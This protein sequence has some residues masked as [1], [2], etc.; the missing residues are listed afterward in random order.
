[1]RSVHR[2]VSRPRSGSGLAGWTQSGAGHEPQWI[3]E[4]GLVEDGPENP[5][6]HSCDAAAIGSRASRT[7]T[8]ARNPMGSHAWQAA[9][10]PGAA[11]ASAYQVGR[12]RAPP[13][14]PRTPEVLR[15]RARAL[16][17]VRTPFSHA[18]GMRR[19]EVVLRPI[20]LLRLLDSTF[21]GNPP[22]K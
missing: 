17:R 8:H 20:S 14:P 22:W 1:M 5:M 18:S 2:A 9:G 19:P 16:A 13:T 3:T 21:P 6:Y 15:I 7:P 12:L 10:R 11:Q 4:T